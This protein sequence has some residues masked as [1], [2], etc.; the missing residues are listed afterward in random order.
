MRRFL[1]VL[2]L[3]AS[4]AGSVH[5]QGVPTGNRLRLYFLGLEGTTDSVFATPNG[6]TV[7]AVV[8]AYDNNGWGLTAFTFRVYYDPAVV[9]FVSAR[10]SCPDSV[11]SPLQTPV[12]GANYVELSAT[13]CL[14]VATSYSHNVA[15]VRL[16]LQAGATRGSALSIEPRALTD[17][18]AVNRTADG[19]GDLDEL[20]RAVG[21]WGDV[22][23]DAVVNSRDALIA[24]SNAVGLPTTGFQVSRGDV[25]ADGFVGSRDALAMLSAS[26]GYPPASGFRTG[27]GIATAC[28]P[29]VV[30]PRSLV[31]LR[32]VGYTAIPGTSGLAVRAA[33]D[34]ATTV[35]GDSADPQGDYGR[36]RV[37]PDGGRVVFSCYRQGYPNICAANIDGSGFTN[38]T[39]VNAYE[40]SPDWSPD[41]SRIVFVRYNQIWTMNADGTGQ[42]VAPGTPPSINVYHVAW[43]PSAG[44]RRVAYIASTGSYWALRTVNVDTAGTDSLVFSGTS[45]QAYPYWPDWSPAGDSLVFS[46]VSNGM[47]SVWKTSRSGGV[48]AR[49]V[50]IQG[51]NDYRQPAWTDQGLLVEQYFESPYPS[52]TRLVLQRP[53]GRVERI[54][55]DTQDNVAPGMDRQ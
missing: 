50:T 13:G 43:D 51:S 30:L 15:T 9:T 12:V 17:R 22:D 2:G 8:R 29:E 55:R 28:A 21:V 4:A 39:S 19:E 1:L 41:G 42:V 47:Y 52:R 53:D 11:A 46:L 36:P 34:S 37:S 54:R 10:S 49:A 3:L 32:R 48:L 44:S 16:Q 20:C 14:G 31:F 5:A 26:I 45:V 25:D 23:D 33:N 18:A 40:Y 6:G 7:D 35:V 24:L 38:L 27:R